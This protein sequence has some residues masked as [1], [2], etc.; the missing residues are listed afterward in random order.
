[1][2]SIRPQEEVDYAPCQDS[3]R[4]WPGYR[5]PRF[6]GHATT[7][8]AGECVAY[9]QEEYGETPIGDNVGALLESNYN[10]VFAPSDLLEVGIHG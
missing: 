7:F 9:A 2:P 5:L 3:W 10:S 4:L 8:T 1:M 6:P